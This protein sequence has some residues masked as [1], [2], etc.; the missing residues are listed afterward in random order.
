[1]SAVTQPEVR[2]QTTADDD[3]SHVVCCNQQLSLCGE[4]LDGEWYDGR[5]AHPC[6]RCDEL[7]KAEVPCG[8]RACLLRRFMRGL[9]G[10]RRTA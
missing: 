10:P 3:T 9:I 6:R 1:M 7:D 8:A 2:D 5:S 4:R